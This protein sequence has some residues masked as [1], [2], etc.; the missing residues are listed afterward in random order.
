ML[1]VFPYLKGFG[2]RKKPPR[3]FEFGLNLHVSR[4]IVVSENRVNFEPV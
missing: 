3:T 2:G 4:A 1:F